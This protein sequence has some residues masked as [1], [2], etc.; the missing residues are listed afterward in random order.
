[1]QSDLIS[2]NAFANIPLEVLIQHQDALV[3]RRIKFVVE[4]GAMARLFRD[5]THQELQ[6]ALLQ[7]IKP[8]RLSSIRTCAEYDSWLIETIKSN[9]WKRFSR[10]GLRSDRWS[11]FAKLVNIVV[12]EIISNREVFPDV[13]WQRLKPYLHIPIDSIVI[14]HLCVQEPEFPRL[15]RLKGMTKETYLTIQY[16]A[17]ALAKKRGVW[18][19][20]FEAAWSARSS[21][22]TSRN[23]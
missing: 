4:K 23:P 13:G 9:R 14:A 10:N 12:Y 11:Y 22:P 6:E 21:L 20:W 17:R 3:R 1:M 19:I 2:E 18:P 15:T 8:S 7:F 5:G 16:A